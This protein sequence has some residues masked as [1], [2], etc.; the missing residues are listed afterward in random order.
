MAYTQTAMHRE[1]TVPEIRKDVLIFGLSFIVFS[2]I[3]LA[4]QL[5]RQPWRD[6][7]PGAEGVGSLFGG[8]KAAVYTF[9][10]HLI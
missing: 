10:S 8:V 7:L 1:P 4:G 9:M 2:V 6:W 3:A 5:L